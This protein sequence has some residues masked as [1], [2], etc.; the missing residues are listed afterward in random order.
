M[1]EPAQGAPPPGHPAPSPP[2]PPQEPSR[3]DYVED[4]LRSVKRWLAVTAA[5]AMAATAIAVVAFVIASDDDQM[6]ERA[7][8]AVLANA[9]DLRQLD[10]GLDALDTRVARLPTPGVLARVEQR[11]KVVERANASFDDRLRGL[12]RLIRALIERVETLEQAP[13]AAPTTT[14]G[15]TTTAP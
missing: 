5:W 7:D 4:D 12:L 2:P 11:L 9:R 13:E 14:S 3:T 15:E 10:R 1:T 6:R 8:S